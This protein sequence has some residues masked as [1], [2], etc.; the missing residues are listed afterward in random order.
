MVQSLTIASFR[1]IAHADLCSAFFH[2][3]LTLIDFRSFSVQSS[4]LNSGLPA[5]LLLSEF[6]RDTFFRSYHQTF[7][8]DGQPI[9]V[10]LLLFLLQY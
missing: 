6:P 1:M 5:F 3:L 7:L 10:F 8:L 9:L 2:Y 4:H